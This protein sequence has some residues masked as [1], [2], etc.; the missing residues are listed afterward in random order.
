MRCALS[1]AGHNN[2][3]EFNRLL[4]LAAPLIVNN[5]A[6]AGMGLADT[7]MSGYISAEAQAA[8][9]VGSSVW[10]LFFLFALGT[11]MAI[12][13]ISSTHRGAGRGHLIGRYARQGFWLSL[14]ISAIVV[15]TMV[16]VAVPGL[17]VIG[18]DAAVRPLAAGYLLAIVCGAPFGFAYLTLRYT[19]E[20]IGWTR[21]V[22]F[23]SV[24]ALPVNVVANYVLMFG[25]W[26]APELGAVGAG[27]GSALTMV[28][29]CVVLLV[30]MVRSPRYASYAIFSLGRGPRWAEMREILAFGVPI[31]VS[32]LAE[33]GLFGG[34]TLLMGKLSAQIAAG[35]IIAMNYASTMFMIPMGLNSATT[36]LVSNALGRRE[37]SL[38]RARG[39]LGIISCGLF[40]SLSAGG[41]LLFRETV[42]GWY[43]QDPAVFEVAI[44]LL[45]VA[46]VFQVSDGIQVGAAGALRGLHDTRVPM[47]LTFFSYW[48]I[49]FP[50]AYAAALPLALSPPMIWSGFVVG[51]SVAAVLLVLRFRHVSRQ[52]DRV[53]T[54][55]DTAAVD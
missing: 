23:V 38:A 5:L 11:L 1:E 39:Y 27:Y 22:M 51:L 16:F 46:A 40:M 9:G 6:L 18:I 26:G 35:H 45:L 42:V 10:M 47:F 55:V 25:K 36:I 28:F 53:S 20:G 29:M 54:V 17:T 43:T 34:V 14:I 4:T 49:G 32:I 52:H 3:V 7:L 24:S 12:S 41:L 2:T 37:L 21:P 8:V 19:T 30:Y 31:M 44:S 50:L 48:I 33:A 13:P 15:T